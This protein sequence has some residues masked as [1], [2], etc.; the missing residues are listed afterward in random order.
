MTEAGTMNTTKRTRIPSGAP[1]STY[2]AGVWL[3][4]ACWTPATFSG[5]AV[6]V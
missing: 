5:G 2:G 1:T 6:I 3:S 4:P